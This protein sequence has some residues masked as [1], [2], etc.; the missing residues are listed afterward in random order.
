M[1]PRILLG[2]ALLA[3]GSPAD[4]AEARLVLRAALDLAVAQDHQDPA[5]ELQA[6]LAQ[7][8]V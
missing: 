3:T 4:R 1:M 5:A 6:L 8:A 7:T 2:K